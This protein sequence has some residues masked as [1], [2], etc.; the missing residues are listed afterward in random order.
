M[1]ILLTGDYRRDEFTRAVDEM[2]RGAEVVRVDVLHA[3]ADWLQ[4]EKPVDLV[5]VA[6]ARP[7][8]FSLSQIEAVRRAA[9]L[10]PIVG[11]L[12]SWCEGEMR[13]GSPWPG[14]TRVYWHQWGERFRR[15]IAKLACGQPGEWTQP[16][17][18]T[19]E[20]RL[21]SSERL[22]DNHGSRLAAVVSDNCEIAGWLAAVCSRRGMPAVTLRGAPAGQID[23]VSILLW[24]AGLPSARAVEAF[25]LGLRQFPGCRAV[26]LADFP[27]EDDVRSFLAAGAAG[28]LSKVDVR[29]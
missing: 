8:Q 10:A 21:L 23:G 18:A 19:S 22:A 20:E 7:G 2:S 3:A 25:Q 28:V 1:R 14:V 17:T 5:V 24:D 11:L 26:V 4:K 16:L 27:R 9:P 13:S 12:G 29:W 6:A 15:E